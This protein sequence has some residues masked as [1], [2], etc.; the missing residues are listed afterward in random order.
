MSDES[1]GGGEKTFDPTPQRLEEARK[2][3]DIPRS[4]DLTAA[5]VYLAFLGVVSTVGGFA[6]QQAAST[7]M[8]FCEGCGLVAGVMPDYHILARTL[9]ELLTRGSR[10]GGGHPVLRVKSEDQ[11]FG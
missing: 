2:K 5:A 10:D 6:V 4:N 9:V 1:S 8:V 3:G 11:V 7:L